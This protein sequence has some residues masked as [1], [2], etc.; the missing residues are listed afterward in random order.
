M[1]EQIWQISNWAGANKIKSQNINKSPN[2][3]N[4]D[5]LLHM[6]KI[7]VLKCDEIRLQLLFIYST[8]V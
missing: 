4:N 7:T 1:T 5:N 8:T 6:V 2:A 3:W